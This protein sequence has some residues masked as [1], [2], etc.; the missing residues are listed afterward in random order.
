MIGHFIDIFIHLDVH[1]EEAINHYGHWVYALLF[2][3]IFCETGLV[4]TPFLPGD[5][6][7]FASGMFAAARVTGGANALDITVLLPLLCIAAVTGNMLNYQI[8][9][10]V[11]PRIFHS[12]RFR[13]LNR[14]H[15]EETHVFY[16]KHGPITLVIARFLPI[17]RTFAPFLAGVGKMGYFSFSIYNT[18]GSLAWVALFT[19]S[20]YFFGN[21]PAVRKN[22]T[23]VIMAII[24][25]SVLP[26]M[27]AFL[28]SKAKK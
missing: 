20:G 16:E 12:T 13:L 11:G 1:L 27:I 24:V 23:A 19:L 5:S 3:I 6:L 28:R 25:V 21:I 15:L 14:K 18:A 22:F 7:L 26:S 2:L 8:G 10:F 4:V 9:Y 17:I